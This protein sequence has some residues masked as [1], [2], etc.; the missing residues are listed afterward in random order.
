MV[1]KCMR[2]YCGFLF[3]RA[4]EPDACPDCGG[5]AIRPANLME[6]QEYEASRNTVWTEKSEEEKE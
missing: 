4:G 1:Y 6:Q 2:K 3:S 5:Q